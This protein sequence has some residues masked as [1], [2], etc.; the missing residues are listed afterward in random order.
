M[1]IKL[2]QILGGIAALAF[3]FSNF[4]YAL[5]WIV[6]GYGTPDWSLNFWTWPIDFVVKVAAISIFTFVFKNNL[7]RYVAAGIYLLSR[8]IYSIYFINVNEESITYLAELFVDFPYWGSFGLTLVAGIFGFLSFVLFV[9]AVI[10]S[11]LYLP[12]SGNAAPGD[13]GNRPTPISTH[14]PPTEPKK[15]QGRYAD[16]EVLGDLLEKG[17]LTQKEFDLKKREILGLDQ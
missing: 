2:P 17:L 4:F 9:L 15:A 5:N 14:I 10:L 1:K 3:I 16:I 13:S 7:L 12:Q 6:E 11:F 8:L